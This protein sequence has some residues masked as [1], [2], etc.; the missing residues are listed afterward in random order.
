M[1]EGLTSPQPIDKIYPPVRRPSLSSD[2]KVNTKD[3]SKDRRMSLDLNWKSVLNR[4]LASTQS[5]SSSLISV[6]K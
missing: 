5:D 1:D 4:N 3:L 6:A 2:I